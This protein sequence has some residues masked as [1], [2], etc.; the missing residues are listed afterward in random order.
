[1]ALPGTLVPCVVSAYRMAFSCSPDATAD[2]AVTQP[3]CRLCRLVC[4]ARFIFRLPVHLRPLP[5]R[6]A[7]LLS[8]PGESCPAARKHSQHLDFS[9]CRS[10]ADESAGYETDGE[11]RHGL[12]V[13]WDPPLFEGWSH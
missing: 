5:A 3:G 11:S 9:V 10:L 8:S 6:G 13:E 12:Y 2:L 7:A 1:M 4:A